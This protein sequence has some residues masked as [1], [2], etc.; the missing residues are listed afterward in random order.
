MLSFFGSR[1]ISAPTNPEPVARHVERLERIRDTSP[2]SSPNT[3]KG[4][5]IKETFAVF[6]AVYAGMLLSEVRQAIP[7]GGLL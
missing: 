6:S 3:S 1:G 5:L 4:A 2:T 7:N